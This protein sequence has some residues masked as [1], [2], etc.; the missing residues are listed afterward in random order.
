MR[1]GIGDGTAQIE[2][3]END[4]QPKR[5]PVPNQAILSVYL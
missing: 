5:A 2:R 4:N 1:L 3:T